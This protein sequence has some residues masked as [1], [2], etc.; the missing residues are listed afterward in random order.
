MLIFIVSVF[1]AP[2]EGWFR[3]GTSSK[4]SIFAAKENFF[5]EPKFK[6]I[7]HDMHAIASILRLQRA[8]Q[9]VW[10]L[11]YKIA[12]HCSLPEAFLLFFFAA[13]YSRSMWRLE[14]L[15][16]S[17]DWSAFITVFA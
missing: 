3:S 1:V 5:I 14:S 4:L 16:R 10:T 6:C 9:Q 8:R 17:F 13:K 2:S 11:S 7:A 12:I 15:T